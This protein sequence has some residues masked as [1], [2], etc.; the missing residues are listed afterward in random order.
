M[1]I[2]LVST[3]LYP[4][5]T[6]GPALSTYYLARGLQARG[7]R[8][9]VASTDMDLPP[10]VPRNRLVTRYGVPSWYLAGPRRLY[11]WLWQHVGAADVVHVGSYFWPASLVCAFIARV[12]G[13]PLVVSP[14]GELLPVAMRYDWWRKRLELPLSRL[15]Y[16]R[17]TFHI[18]R[19]EEA[20]A[21]RRL[22]P[23]AAVFE[24]PNLIGAKLC[25]S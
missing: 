6:G 10:D 13:V 7:V 24:A 20:D 16:R 19:P 18:T 17:A 22:F 25:T 15:V 2:L 14:R 8:V 1:R 11:A 9:V 5:S 23:R 12:R 4:S 21:L 3:H